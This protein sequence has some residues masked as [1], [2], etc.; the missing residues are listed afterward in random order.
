[1]TIEVPS[2]SARTLTFECGMGMFKGA[3][4]VK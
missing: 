4:L 2:D 3:L 1:V